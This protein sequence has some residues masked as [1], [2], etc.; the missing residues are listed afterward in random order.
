MSHDDSGGVES[1]LLPPKPL[2][3]P[4]PPS[5]FFVQLFLF[6]SSSVLYLLTFSSILFPSYDPLSFSLIFTLV[7]LCSYLL[8]LSSFSFYFLSPFLL[9]SFIFP[10]IPLVLSTPMHILS[11]FVLCFP[12]SFPLSYLHCLPAL[13]P[14]HPQ[15]SSYLLFPSLLYPLSL[16]HIFYSSPLPHPHPRLFSD[17]LFP[18]QFPFSLSF[19]SPVIH[20]LIFYVSHSTQ[21]NEGQYLSKQTNSE[22]VSECL[23]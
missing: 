3:S 19:F 2:P 4:L 20:C 6:L 23:I 17:F 9:S 16:L 1:L 22:G 14:P 15:I 13:L 5:F 7:F 12:C 8:L 18:S 11:F 21:S 10:F